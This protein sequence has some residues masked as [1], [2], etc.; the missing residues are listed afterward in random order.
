MNEVANNKQR[1]FNAD[2]LIYVIIIYIVFSLPQ[3]NSMQIKILKFKIFIYLFISL[4]EKLKR[5]KLVMLWSF[6]Q[7]LLC[8]SA[9]RVA[10]LFCTPL[11]AAL[12]HRH[13]DF[14]GKMQEPRM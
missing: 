12:T 2:P 6:G 9:T 3:I 5:R 11:L 8:S 13:L 7:L 10:Q 1:Q 4:D 14:S